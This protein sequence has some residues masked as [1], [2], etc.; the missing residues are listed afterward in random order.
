VLFRKPFLLALSQLQSTLAALRSSWSY[1]FGYP[2]RKLVAAVDI[3]KLSR[4]KHN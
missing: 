3:H 4:D 2:I 1:S